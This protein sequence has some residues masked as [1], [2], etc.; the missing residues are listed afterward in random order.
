MVC[1]G[2]PITLKVEPADAGVITVKHKPIPWEDKLSVL[3]PPAEE[4]PVIKEVNWGTTAQI[5]AQAKAGYRFKRW[6]FSGSS[7]KIE[8]KLTD[9]PV[10][11]G[12]VLYDVEDAQETGRTITAIFERMQSEPEPVP[13]PEPIPDPDNGSIRTINITGNPSKLIINFV[14]E[15]NMP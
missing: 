10:E 7:P 9:N 15:N 5:F 14:K 8:D 4:Y 12:H 11:Y 13:E 1:I 6:V 3:M 2:P